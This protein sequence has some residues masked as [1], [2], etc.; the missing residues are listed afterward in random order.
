M[1]K[2]VCSGALKEPHWFASAVNFKNYVP[3]KE[4][5]T[6]LG[7]LNV[8]LNL[9]RGVKK[10]HQFDLI[11]GDL[12][13]GSFLMDPSN[14]SVIIRKIAHLATKEF[15]LYHIQEDPEFAAPE[16]LKS[17]QA[18]DSSTPRTKEH[19]RH[20]LSTLIYHVLLRRHPLLGSPVFYPEAD[21]NRSVLPADKPLFIENP[22]HPY[23]RLV[24]SPGNEKYM[25]WI[26]AR[27]LPS[28]VLGPHLGALF[29]RA[30]TDGLVDPSQRPEPGDWIDA[31]VKTRDMLH[32]CS[33]PECP[34]GSFV[35]NLETRACPYCGARVEDP[36]PY[37]EFHTMSGDKYIDESRSLFIPGN[38]SL[39]PWHLDKNTVPNE[40]LPPEKTKAAG[41][42]SFHNGKWC[43][44]NQTV[45]DLCYYKGKS[46]PRSVPI[47]QMAEL[48]EDLVFF[49]PA[50]PVPYRLIVRISS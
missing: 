31:L 50:Q 17:L 40:F 2:S 32:P 6:L 7:Y 49:S 8:C 15:P 18:D 29:F 3:L 35:F 46:K 28:S 19:D 20:S 38:L 14:G 47:N 1:R 21:G 45:S 48:E 26:D 27:D 23:K 12:S 43:F 5:G 22:D 37:L 25:P 42:F 24:L 33:N 11:P 10:L 16:R 13:F 41:Y 44:V 39:Y 34:T 30:F 36:V 9:S 4:R